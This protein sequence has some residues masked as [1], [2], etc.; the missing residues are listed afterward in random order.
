MY[1]VT[2]NLI[3]LRGISADVSRE[4]GLFLQEKFQSGRDTAV[5][6]VV[7]GWELMTAVAAAILDVVSGREVPHPDLK[8]V[9]PS[10]EPIRQDKAA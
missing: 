3:R 2:S 7:L 6:V 5:A 1:R 8:Q 10:P 9:A 4:I